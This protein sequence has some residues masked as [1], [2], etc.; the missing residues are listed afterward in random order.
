MGLGED[1]EL[2][3]VRDTDDF[4]IHLSGEVD[5]L[6]DLPTVYEPEP[7]KEKRVRSELMSTNRCLVQLFYLADTL[8]VKDTQSL[9][10]VNGV[11]PVI[12]SHWAGVVP[13]A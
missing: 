3:H 7:R 9:I 6:L 1:D 4:P 8:V 5:R 13:P 10:K 11:V 2:G 12:S